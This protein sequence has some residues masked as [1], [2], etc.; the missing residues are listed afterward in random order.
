MLMNQR[1]HRG[2]TAA[3]RAE[4][5][6]RWRLAGAPKSIGRMF[7]K[8]SMSVNHQLTPHGGIETPAERIKPGV[9]LPRFRGQFIACAIMK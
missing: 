6:D 5:W 2:F 7:G 9:E 4:L 8:P 3:E 1:N